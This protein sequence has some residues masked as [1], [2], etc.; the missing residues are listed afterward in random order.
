M[1]SFYFQYLKIIG[2]YALIALLKCEHVIK[3]LIYKNLF[4]T[5]K[6]VFYYFIF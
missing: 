4:E 6:T 3:I 5:L 2:N 1:V